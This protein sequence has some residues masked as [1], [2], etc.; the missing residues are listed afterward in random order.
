MRRTATTATANV[1]RTSTRA[2][3]VA[4]HSKKATIKATAASTPTQHIQWR[5]KRITLF[6]TCTGLK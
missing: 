4:K 3:V 5:G 1:K 6:G 2:T